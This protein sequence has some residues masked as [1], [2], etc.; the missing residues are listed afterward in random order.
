[1]IH[2]PSGENRSCCSPKGVWIRG[3]GSPSSDRVHVS[4]E[5]SGSKL[6]ASRVV[7]SGEMSVIYAYSIGVAMT[8]SLPTPEA[9]FLCKGAPALL[10]L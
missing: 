7:P 4:K 1:M 8:S 5:F 10:E 6:V 9:S 3:V 2:S